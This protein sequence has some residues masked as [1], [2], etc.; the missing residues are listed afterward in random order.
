MYELLIFDWDGTLMDSAHK[1]S[2][3]I[4]A[5]ARELELEEPSDQAARNIIGLGLSEAMQ[6]LFPQQS[7]AVIARLVDA[8][9]H[10]WL[11]VN[12][13]EQKAFDGVV[14]GLSQLDKQGVL[15]TVA[16]GKSRAGLNRAFADLD[17]E[18]LFVTSRCADE[19]RSK[20]HPQM[21]EEIL[22][23]T[24]I[25]PHKALMIGDTTYDMDMARFAS[26]PALGVSYGVHSADMLMQSGALAVMDSFNAVLNW[27]AQDRLQAAYR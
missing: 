5:S 20:P 22:E 7:P 2:T 9:R 21:L 11:V 16:T 26:M 8:Y 12:T 15:L 13:T 18:H 14:E 27:L 3:C 4:R 24:A 23:F 1:I 6:Q 19:T 10:Q 25:E 17:I